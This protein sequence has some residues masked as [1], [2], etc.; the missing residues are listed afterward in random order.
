MLRIINEPTAAAIVYGIDEKGPEKMVLVFDLSAAARSTSASWPST[1]ASSRCSAPTTAT[2]TS[3]RGLP[4]I[5]DYFIKLI[6]GKNGR[7]ISGDARALGKLRRECEHAKRALSN[8]HQ[9][10]VE[11]AR[12][13]STASTSR[14]SSPGRAS[15][16]ST[17]TCSARPWC[18]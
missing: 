12:R 1:T 7:D 3:E 18:R 5:M 16:S 14:S 4:P 9:V 15:R 13:C 11:I 17:A 2:P 6:K 10:R 8:Q